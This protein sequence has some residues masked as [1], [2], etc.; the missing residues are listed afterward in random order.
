MV[1]NGSY[2]I[3]GQSMG[4]RGFIVKHSHLAPG[5]SSAHH[6]TPREALM[7]AIESRE[8]EIAKLEGHIEE[9]EAMLLTQIEL[10]EFNN[11][12]K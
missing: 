4:E 6:A 12:E 9:L 8:E 10:E 7:H 11:K 1:S 2:Y 3:R 5:Y